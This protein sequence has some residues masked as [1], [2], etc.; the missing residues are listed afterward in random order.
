MEHHSQGNLGRSLGLQKS[1]APLLGKQEEE[2]RT[3]IGNIFLCT[4]A[5]SQKV[6]VSGGGYGQWCDFSMGYR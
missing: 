2:G 4:P 1:K 5:E 6:G 3:A